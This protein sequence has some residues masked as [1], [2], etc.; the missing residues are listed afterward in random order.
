MKDLP[1]IEVKEIDHKPVNQ[2]HE[3]LLRQANEPPVSQRLWNETSRPVEP[4]R[5]YDW[6]E[7]EAL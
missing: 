5:G 2:W 7:Y 3:R 1:L 4:C 6:Q